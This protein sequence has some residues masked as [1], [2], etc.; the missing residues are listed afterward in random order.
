MIESYIAVQDDD[1][2]FVAVSEL[3]INTGTI[4]LIKNPVFGWSKDGGANNL[5]CRK[6]LL[7]HFF[8]LS[9]L[10]QK[11]CIDHRKLSDKFINDNITLWM[12]SKMIVKYP[13]LKWKHSS[14]HSWQN[15]VGSADKNN[16]K[17]LN[18][19][20]RWRSIWL[21]RS[22]ASYRSSIVQ[23]PWLRC[24]VH[25]AVNMRKPVISHACSGL[26]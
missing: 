14:V 7:C 22:P 13:W 20:H 12:D 5:K 19:K 11:N 2:Q 9:A 17:P 16:T 6:Q 24:K 25:T 8:K 10:F 3:Y 26:I 23:S 4:T 15:G 1:G 21:Q 18:L